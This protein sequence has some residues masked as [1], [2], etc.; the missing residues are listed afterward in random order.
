MD[1]EGAR[2]LMALAVESGLG[3]E[4]EQELA[5]HLV[6]CSECK[7]L[8]EGLQYAQAALSRLGRSDPPT[9]ALEEAI[10]RATTVLR[11][12]ADPGPMAQAPAVPP[13][14]HL[15][16]IPGDAD[17]TTPPPLSPTAFSELE[18]EPEIPEVLTEAGPA[19]EA[20]IAAAADIFEVDTR[21]P[22]PPEPAI[23]TDFAQPTDDLQ[24][25]EPLPPSPLEPIPL[26]PLPSEPVPD[27]TLEPPVRELEPILP[28]EVAPPRS[29][30]P[31]ADLPEP[32]TE[33]A[34]ELPP[35]ARPRGGAGFGAWL[36][37]IAATLVL[38]VLAAY[39][40]T[41]EQGLGGGDLPTPDEVR[42][43]VERV[44]GEMKSL[45]ASF[46][47]RRLD[48]YPV[49]RE[50]QSLTYSFSD[51]EMAGRIVYDRAEGYREQTAVEVGGQEITRTRTVRTQ[52]ETRTL[53]GA[54][55]EAQ[56]TIERNAPLGPP[57][58]TFHPSLGSLERSLSTA[59]AQLVDA[60]ELDVLGVRS[61]DDREVLEVRFPVE[62]TE[63][64]RADLMGVLLDTRTYFPV[65]VRREISRANASVLGPSTVLSD[66]AIATAFGDRDRITTEIVDLRDVVVD[67]I[68]LP[69]DL[70]LDVPEGV[71]TQERD[72][73][74]AAVRRGDL[75]SRL[76][77]TPFFPRSL[78]SGFEERSLAVFTGEPG[79]WGPN[80]TFPAP[81]GV[82]QAIYF[83]GKTTFTITERHM[84]D[85][86]FD[87]KGSPLSGGGIP[88]QTRSVE[89]AE[90]T[91]F[92]AWSP[93]VP[94]HAYGF[95]GNVFA[96]VSGYAPAE[97]LI[98]I[99]SSLGEAPVEAPSADLQV[100][101]SPGTSPTPSPASP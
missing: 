8:Y 9:R 27:L 11:G 95:L 39:I 99:V 32:E 65:H 5:L 58:G 25:E 59:A 45:K 22:L 91:F 43:R 23:P 18:V 96:V 33:P 76:E 79:A 67:D 88:I 4:Q 49:G 83:D 68:I 26:E 87:T 75:A 82:M 51:G 36:A 40:V 14:A 52:E 62:A 31:D 56:L 13:P 70:I 12:E 73:G 42:S 55:A 84:P 74:F 6:G 85:G 53:T 86:P 15:V 30:L 19:T 89:R 47:I 98:E 24:L 93:E 35:E 2:G 57:D 38:A 69:G 94:P 97:Q 16:R 81:D 63:L 34:R 1:H 60:R 100:S 37:A 46:T 7:A 28:V 41:R 20:D 90:K 21:P 78:P 72:A 17:S 50:G 64:S 29:E 44:F 77:F 48:L 3:T 80:N 54:G 61:A 92:Y 66:N 71:E 10:H 101:Q